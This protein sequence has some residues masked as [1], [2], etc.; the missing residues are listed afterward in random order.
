[1]INIKYIVPGYGGDTMGWLPYNTQVKPLPSETKNIVLESIKRKEK[2]LST[3]PAFYLQYSQYLSHDN[4]FISRHYDT[5][6]NL[7]LL[8]TTLEP[9]KYIA[10]LVTDN[11]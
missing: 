11:V 2:I 8:S 6:A 4:W 3:S 10:K 5:F 7:F 1:V 9:E